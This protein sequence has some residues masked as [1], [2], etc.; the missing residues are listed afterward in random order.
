MPNALA[1]P[2]AAI[3]AVPKRRP[4]GPTGPY[5]GMRAEGNVDLTNRPQVRNAD[6]SVS[7]VRSASFGMD[8]GEILVPTVSEDGRILSD[9]EA[10]DQY[11]KT[12]RHLGIFDTPEHAT[13]Y[14]DALHN[15]QADYKPMNNALASLMPRP[16][17][18]GV[19][20]NMPM[21]R[22]PVPGMALPT[23]VAPAP[24]ARPQTNALAGVQPSWNSQ[25][26]PQQNM[27]LSSAVNG[28]QR[29]LDPKGWQAGQDQ[30]K[31]DKAEGV[32]KQI[33]MLQNIRALP[34]EQRMQALPQISQ[35]IGKQIPPELM[36]DQAIDTHLAMLMGEA[37][38]APSTPEPMSEYQRAQ[39]GIEREKL[40]KP[41]PP[42]EV[43]GVLVDPE[44][45]EPVYTSPK[46]PKYF[47]TGQAVVSVGPD[48]KPS[49]LYRDPQQ[50]SGSTAR[51]ENIS[52]AEMEALGY[53]KGTIGQRNIITN[54]V[55]VKSRPSTQ[56]TGQPTESERGAGLHATVSI[57][58]L[59]NIMAKEGAG[60]N[61]A[62]GM[63][64]MG[65]LVGGENERLYD[66]AADE[67]IDGYLRAMTGA[68]A[69]KNEIDTYK[70]Q[71]FPAFGD[72]DAVLKQKSAGRLNALKGMKSKAGRAWNPEWDTIIADLEATQPATQ[73][74]ASNGPKFPDGTPIT[75]E[76]L[77]KLP[78]QLQE[79]WSKLLPPEANNDPN[80]DAFIDSLFPADS[81]S[82]P[83][84]GG[85]P[86]G[87]TQEEWDAM[88]PEEQAL[89]Q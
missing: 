79:V 73:A 43:N 72:T 28:F 71:W 2:L 52:A 85:L 80:D 88:T 69:T 65:G 82:Q 30:A 42:I 20:P 22:L 58:G 89:F 75:R 18:Q 7:S 27:L 21:R 87:V 81:G 35:S 1:F 76:N 63:E 10:L 83:D 16:D 11:R 77:Q 86:A 12:G 50:Q 13:S 57:N 24:M 45:Y 15:A 23:A 68:A 33:A 5:A 54:Q 38:M 34:M 61:R 78:P 55:D 4:G 36:Q 53:P 39:I 62:G 32:K 6:G 51:Y 17:M 3:G 47:N 40:N 37:G 56:Q 67:F 26:K 64:Q 14:A 66:Q 25:P 31:A 41:K 60:Y 84:G 48:G 9:D 49:V 46:D 29:G 70:R 44:T 59:R 8:E 74:S 19:D